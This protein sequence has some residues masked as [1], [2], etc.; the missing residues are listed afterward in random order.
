MQTALEKLPE[1]IRREYEKNGPN[2]NM[3]NVKVQS[4]SDYLA[5]FSS[6]LKTDET[7][8]FRGHADLIWTIIPSALRY[9][10]QTDRE[11]ALN[12]VNIF[13]RFMEIKLDKPPSAGEELKWVQLAQHYGLPTRLLDWTTNTA[14]A[15][16][17]ACLEQNKNGLVLVLNP[18]DLNKTAD[19][20]RPRV[21]DV[22]KDSALINSYLHLTG[23]LDPKNG[24]KTIAVHPIW[25][26]ERIML[27]QGVFT[28][29]GSKIFT[30]TGK[31]APSLVYV[32]ILKEFK[33]D[34]LMELERIGVSEMSIFPEPEHLCAYLRKSEKLH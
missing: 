3:V 12:L 5:V 15:L 29:H 34:L 23:Q 19:P 2:C 6:V 10:R 32:P 21:F 7:F 24:F 18:V 14:I 16:Y 22:N 17:F 30:L 13:K 11:K 28:L 4:L 1:Q 27:Q 33:K 26:S 25:N 20:K 8:W 31:Q 9:K